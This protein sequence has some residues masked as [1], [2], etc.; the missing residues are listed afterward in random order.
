[1]CSSDLSQPKRKNILPI[2]PALRPVP[3]KIDVQLLGSLIVLD[4]A[5]SVTRNGAGLLTEPEQLSSTISTD[6]TALLNLRFRTGAL[7]HLTQDA[8][9]GL[10]GTAE[11]YNITNLDYSVE[12]QDAGVAIHQK[13]P[14][15]TPAQSDQ[16][17]VRRVSVEVH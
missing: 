16:F 3:G 4:V 8:L 13:N 17:W 9:K 10:L 7:A 12:Y 2:D 15:I 11:T 14:D 5:L 6:V 1:M